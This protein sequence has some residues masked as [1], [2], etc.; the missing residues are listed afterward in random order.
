MQDFVTRS[1]SLDFVKK[2][3]GYES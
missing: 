1:V 3:G 2:L